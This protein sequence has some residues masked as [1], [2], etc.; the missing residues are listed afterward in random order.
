MHTFE[1][2]NLATTVCKGNFN[3]YLSELYITLGYL[4]IS[5]FVAV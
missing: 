3:T 1:E 4:R 2:R 5:V